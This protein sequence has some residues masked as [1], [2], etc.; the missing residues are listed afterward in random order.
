MPN[1]SDI[2]H[3]D[4]A[5]QRWSVALFLPV[6][7]WDPF[8][9]WPF[10]IAHLHSMNELSLKLL[11]WCLGPSEETDQGQACWCSALRS[12]QCD[13]QTHPAVIGAHVKSSCC[14]YTHAHALLCL[15]LQLWRWIVLLWSKKKTNKLGFPFNRMP[16]ESQHRHHLLCPQ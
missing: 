10:Q 16:G 9:K 8:E 2:M 3:L 4:N 12:K 14:E 11:F 7:I 15:I 13:S 6:Y 5:F 1:I